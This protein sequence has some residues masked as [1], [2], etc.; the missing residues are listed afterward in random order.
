VLAA[1]ASDEFEI[2]SFTYDAKPHQDETANKMQSLAPGRSI[3]G[4]SDEAAANIIR[5]DKLDLLID[6]SGHTS[7]RR[8]SLL[9][10]RPAPVQACFIGYPSTTGF[11]GVDWLIGDENLFPP[12]A[13]KFYSEGLAR[14]PDSFLAFAPPSTMPRP[15]L[16]RRAGPITFGSLNHLPKLNDDVLRVW[17]CVLNRVADSR[18]L[19]Q[20]AAFA[21]AESIERIEKIFAAHGVARDQLSLTAPQPFA[22]AMKRYH[23]IDIALDPFPYNGGT[24]TAHALWMGVPV[25]TKAGDYF[26]RRMGVSL[27]NAAGLSQFTASD[28]D[29]YVQ[30]ATGLASDIQ[31]GANMRAAILKSNASAALFDTKKYAR[32][33]AHIYRKMVS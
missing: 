14:A 33:L 4:M 11:R 26:C 15:L 6:L 10:L 25:V 20:C 21:E 8:L 3:E 7:G 5:E 23:E 30:I 1:H 22:E 9:G 19:L 32:S 28:D 31:G 12:G 24:T 18:L 27:L 16:A 2:D 13:E 29:D 17:A